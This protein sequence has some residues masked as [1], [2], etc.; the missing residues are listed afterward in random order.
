MTRSKSLLIGLIATLL[1]VI[2][3]FAQEDRQRHTLGIDM[4]PVTLDVVVIDQRGSPV[5]GLQKDHFKAY[6]AD[7]QQT[8]TTF[9]P[10][11][12]PVTVAILAELR[13]I[14]GWDWHDIVKPA[15]RFIQ[16][17]REDDWAA[18]VFYDIRP[19]TLVDFTKDKRVL[20][21]GLQDDVRTPVY[22]AASLY[23]A[24]CST[25]D[26][27]ES[28][29]GKKA[30]LLLSTGLDTVSKHNYPEMMRKA[31][32]SNTVIYIINLGS[33]NP[34]FADRTMRFLARQ[35]GGAAFIEDIHGKYWGIHHEPEKSLDEAIETV[36]EYVKHQYS[37]SFVPK[38]L[39]KDGKLHK[40]RVE[41]IDRDLSKNGKPDTLSV[42]HKEGY[43]VPKS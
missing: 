3:T 20:L 39:K 11:E 28:I 22:R 35:T 12:A 41:V 8:I 42:R 13:Y 14:A 36:G 24:M 21:Q 27:L 25:L 37:I 6:E 30:I 32:L 33:N 5:A 34:A 43:Y 17:L 10:A 2:A 23:D 9:V 1:S 16:S 26:R 29:S 19:E 31:E 18:L 15:A 38:N 4:G 7:V 40:I